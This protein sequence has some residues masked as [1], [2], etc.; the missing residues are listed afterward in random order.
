MPIWTDPTT[1]AALPLPL[2]N[3]AHTRAAFREF[4]A[5][6][7]AKAAF[8]AT[9][10]AFTA[11]N[12]FAADTTLGSAADLI[13]AKPASRIRPGTTSLAV[14]NNANSRDNFRVDDSGNV[15]VFGTIT[16][17]GLSSGGAAAFPG[18]VTAN[19]DNVSGQ[20]FYLSDDGEIVDLQDTYATARFNGGLRV[21]NAKGG[22]TVRHEFQAGGN[23]SHTG[24]LTTGNYVDVP[25]IATPGNPATSHVRF[26][27]KSDKRLYAKNDAGVES[28]V[29]GAIPRSFAAEAFSPIAGCD[30]VFRQSGT[31][32]WE[33][34]FQN[35]TQGYASATFAM[36][37]NWAGGLVRFKVWSYCGG[38]QNVTWRIGAVVLQSG[39]SGDTTWGVVSDQNVSLGASLVINS[40]THDW[41]V[42]A[43][44]AGYPVHFYLQRLTSSGFD[45]NTATVHMKVVDLL[46]G[47]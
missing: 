7:D 26:Y 32:R 4:G 25:I 6:I 45:S 13:M 2:G 14:R 20:G 44:F 41:T 21:T 36:P 22:N 8:L 1:R 19:T 10:N 24:T 33:L 15:T 43:S 31:E 39:S 3:Q 34:V 38:A 23:A 37:Q 42:P 47:A 11:A 5:D 35:G 27:A 16:A 29:G 18:N 28:I 40:T 17:A 12:S 9:V 46:M 30:P